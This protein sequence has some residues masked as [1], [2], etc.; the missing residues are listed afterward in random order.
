MAMRFLPVRRS[1]KRLPAGERLANQVPL[2]E[3]FAFHK[4]KPWNSCPRK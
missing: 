1:P 2:L 3:F 4:E